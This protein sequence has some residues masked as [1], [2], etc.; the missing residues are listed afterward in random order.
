M[1]SKL[2]TVLTV[3]CLFVLNLPTLAQVNQP[4]SSVEPTRPSEPF[5][6]M[7]PIPTS[8]PSFDFKASPQ[9]PLEPFEV[10][11]T[12][13]VREIEV[14]GS[15][16]FSKE[17]LNEVTKPFIN[18]ALTFEQVLAIRS[19]ITNLYRSEGYATSGAF[20]PFQDFTSGKLQIQVVQGEIESIEIEGLRRLNQNYVRSRLI[21]ATKAP[22]NILQ[23]EQA[24]Q[25]LQL[26]PL[27][28]KINVEFTAGSSPGR[29][30][31]LISFQEA[32]PIN[33][34]IVVDNKEPPSVGSLG[35]TAIL[36]HNNLLGFGDRL[37]VARG[38]TQGV[39]NYSMSYQIPVNAQN[40]T[41]GLRYTRGRNEVISEPFAPLE[42]TGRAQ[43]YAF[44]FRQPV[45]LTPTEELAF[46]VSAQLRRSRTFLF[47][48]EPFSFTEGPEKGESKVSVLRFSTDWLNRRS[49]NTV[50]AARSTFSLGLG[51]LDATV[52]DTG[53]DGRFVSWQG[54][55]QWVQGLNTRRDTVL[56]SRVVAQLT[57]DS[58]LPLE[59]FAIGGPDSV[60]GYST[61]QAVASNG[62][63][64]SVEV[65][66]PIVR[67]E[68]GFGLL[69]LTPFVDVGTVWGSEL[70]TDTLLSTGL[71]LRWQL[72]KS[73]LARIDWGIPLISI[74]RQGDS[75]Q[76]NGISFSLQFNPF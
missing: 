49:P 23:L 53:T 65:R 14:L 39:N 17:E 70:S 38:I 67:E 55:F 18:K 27:F 22:V 13:T 10:E 76:D 61:N 32:N 68:S 59:Q 21:A 30:V 74:D 44:D 71:G 35:G 29:N 73:V 8:P 34:A 48:D 19:A 24:L 9:I 63:F 69:Q 57:P 33:G 15:T 64:G 3:N 56:I 37:D 2:A 60:R 52:N 31:L 75:L 36:I 12:V 20:L 50:L 46:G 42:I 62:I 54:Q 1:Y 11:D 7:L 47:D 45:I 41:L 5:P 43:T 58:L 51:S 25:L 4:P 40:G 28:D 6:Q 16:V 26:N 72:G 66:L